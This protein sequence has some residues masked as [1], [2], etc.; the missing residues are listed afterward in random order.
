MSANKWYWI[1]GVAVYFCSLLLRAVKWYILVTMKKRVVFSTFLAMYLVNSVAGNITPFKSGEA[2]APFLMKKYFGVDIGSG[3]SVLLFD[4]ILEMI[5]MLVFLVVS[6]VYLLLHAGIARVF[7]YSIFAAIVLLLV[8]LFSL[9][10]VGLNEKIGYG[11]LKGFNRIIKWQVYR[12]R[13]PGIRNE[14]QTFYA[15]RQIIN[16]KWKMALLFVL[17]GVCWFAQ[18]I[19]L[20]LVV[21]STFP[22]AFMPSVVAQGI[23]VPVSLISFVP[24]GMGV[25]AVSYQYIMSLFGYP[26]DSVVSAALFS[27]ILFMGLI[28]CS[29]FLASFALRQPE[30]KKGD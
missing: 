16:E 26:F 18:F 2:V 4:R 5:W 9:L 13:A 23:A 10:L 14:L 28:F 6:F 19:A 29:G 3:V 11:L 30:S 25:T 8:L 20:W 27:K 15:G 1:T 21:L 24:A 17:T 7:G 12:K 22:V